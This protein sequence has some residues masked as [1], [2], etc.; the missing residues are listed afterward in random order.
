MIV[1]KSQG[2]CLGENQRYAY[3]CYLYADQGKKECITAEECKVFGRY[4]YYNSR[5]CVSIQPASDGHFAELIEDIWICSHK[6]INRMLYFENVA[7]C[8]PEAAC[9]FGKPGGIG[10]F[11]SQNDYYYY[12]CI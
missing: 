2:L 10:Y 7:T 8:I 3:K 11:I 12:Y 1:Y 5:T 9:F 6:K 4:A